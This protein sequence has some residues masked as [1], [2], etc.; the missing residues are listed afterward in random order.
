M[1]CPRRVALALLVSLT[2]LSG[3]LACANLATDSDEQLA[4]P[5]ALAMRVTVAPDTV[6][7]AGELT[8]TLTATNPLAVGIRAPGPCPWLPIRLQ[9]VGADSVRRY[10]LIGAGGGCK[11]PDGPATVRLP[12]GWT[13]SMMSRGAAGVVLSSG[14]R[15][16]LYRLRGVY[17]A[18][19]DTAFGEWVALWVTP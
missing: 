9:V 5:S 17:A 15:P 13:E 16:G 6:A 11:L 12:P 1:M 8:L 2:C 3:A 14:T 7:V 19:A 10:A 4:A 18:P